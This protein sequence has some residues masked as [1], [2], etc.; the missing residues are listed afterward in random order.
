LRGHAKTQPQHETVSRGDNLRDVLAAY[1]L[2]GRHGGVDPSAVAVVG[3]SYG[4]YLGAILTS[5]RAVRWLSLRAPALYKDA[6]WELP[7][8][9]LH[10]DPD[11]AAYRRRAVP[12]ED[13]RPLCACEASPG[14][15]LR[16]SSL[17]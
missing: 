4:G 8:R 11:L 6:N 16:A 17:H 2:L 5:L 3:S 7:K 9:Q 13:T 10:H 15:L 14:E 1:D 12:P